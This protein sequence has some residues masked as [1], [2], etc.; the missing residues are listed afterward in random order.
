MTKTGRPSLER[1]VCGTLTCVGMGVGARVGARV[2][3]AVAVMV[4]RSV[5]GTLTRSCCGVPI[6]IAAATTS[7]SPYLSFVGEVGLMSMRSARPATTSLSPY[8]GPSE[9]CARISGGTSLIRGGLAEVAPCAALSTAAL[10][11]PAGTA[12]PAASEVADGGATH[13]PSTEP[14]S[15]ATV[16]SAAP[17]PS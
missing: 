2:A 15:A 13:T 17:P 1:S 16:A 10:T 3:V 14:S 4:E 11:A 8:C 7:L 6:W 12:A 5:C 9:S